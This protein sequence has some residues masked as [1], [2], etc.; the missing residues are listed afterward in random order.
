MPVSYGQ[1]AGGAVIGDMRSGR[2]ALRAL[3]PHELRQTTPVTLNEP[4]I[5]KKTP[6]VCREYSTAFRA[7]EAAEHQG[8]A[9]EYQKR[10]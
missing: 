8:K 1:R 10:A 4:F 2:G 3:V 7:G 5:H 9:E 6:D